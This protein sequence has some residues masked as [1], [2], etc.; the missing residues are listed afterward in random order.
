MDERAEDILCGL[1]ANPALPD[2]LRALLPDRPAVSPHDAARLDRPPVEPDVARAA[3]P[4]TPPDEVIALLDQSPLARWAL[5]DRPDLP[6]RAQE[7]LAVD[8]LPGVRATLAANA[9]VVSEPLL[10]ELA[11]DE[12]DDVRRSVAHNPSVPLDVLTEIAESTRIGP[13]LMPRV[14]SATDEELRL[15]AASPSARVRMLVAARTALPAEVFTQLVTDDDIRVVKALASHPAL[16]PD[17]LR[18]LAARHGPS[19]FR[20]LATNPHCD[21]ELLHHMA[22]NATARRIYRSVAEHPNTHPETLLLCLEDDN[23]RR[24]AAQHPNLPTNILLNL[25]DDPRLARHAAANPSLP[26]L[27][28]ERLIATHA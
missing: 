2:Q 9:A 7:R 26:V 6:H 3:D 1:S 4:A 14:M 21:P 28:M 19:L 23:A 11:N 18:T 25:L 10:R 5:A 24:W 8:H 12:Y 22:H 20:M 17:Q 15:L 16:S 27:I 13:G